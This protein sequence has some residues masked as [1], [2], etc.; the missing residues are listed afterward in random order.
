[1]NL[2]SILSNTTEKYP[3][4]TALIHLDLRWTYEMLNRRVNRLANALLNS[5]VKKG[6]GIALLFFNS[7]HFVEAYFAAM[8][9][10]AVVTPV[11]FRFIGPEIEYILNDSSAAIFFYGK[12]FQKVVSECR[13]RL[14]HVIR[15]VAVDS[16]DTALAADYEQ[17]MAEGEDAEP[18]AAVNEADACQI[19]YT[20]GT[21]GK[22][23]GAVITHHAVIWNMVNTLWG[24]EDREGEIALIIGPLYHTA[25]LNNHLAIQVA[26]GGTSILI[27]RFN[28]VDVF[29]AIE[30]ERAT[31]ISGSPTMYQL[32]LQNLDAHRFDLSSI[33]KCTVGSAILPVDT[34]RRLETF[35]P[36]VAGI[37]DVY[38]CTEAAPSISV[39]TGKDS[40]RKHGSV[41]RALPFVQVRIVDEADHPVPAGTVGELVCRGPNVMKAYHGQPEATRE[42]FRGGWLHTG[43]MARMDNEGFIYIVD[44]KKDMIISGG[45]N[46]S[47]R[48][49]EEV[50]HIHPL[51]D[52]AAVV[53]VAD[54]LWGEAVRA[55]VVTQRDAELTEADVI[56]HCRRHL[57][58]YKKPKYVTFID[59]IPKNPSGKILKNILREWS[60]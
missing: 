22:P 58:G 42:V 32:L 3:E 49:V 48:E 31:T 55:F 47:P 39:L 29:K 45:E 60:L 25:A 26:L 35:F 23:K 56:E 36:N 4:R 52:D 2:G 54:D 37:Y 10:G 40:I 50:L 51:I 13:P 53:G 12:A 18:E 27:K 28:P 41:G 21:T 9:I 59:E 44:R 15:Y 5:G 34:K 30:K 14:S 11:N 7:N 46:I 19:M 43:D 8:K 1:M 20:S 16:P 38:G 33:T 6:D 57:A 24:R 17:F